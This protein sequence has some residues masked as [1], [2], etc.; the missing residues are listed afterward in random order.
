[1]FGVSGISTEKPA[2]MNLTV[3]ANQAKKEAADR[4]DIVKTMELL[5]NASG[6]SI[7]NDLNPLGAVHRAQAAANAPRAVDPA[8]GATG[9]APGGAPAPNPTVMAIL[10][11]DPVYAAFLAQNGML[12]GPAAPGALPGAI[13]EAV[14]GMAGE[15]YDVARDVQAAKEAA[16]IAAEVVGQSLG[17]AD[18]AAPQA[19][20]APALQHAAVMES[21]PA[22]APAGT[23]AQV[24]VM[25]I[26][27]MMRDPGESSPATVLHDVVESSTG[28]VLHSGLLLFETAAGLARCH[29]GFGDQG[30]MEEILLMDEAC[31]TE[32]KQLS[33]HRRR[34]ELEESADHRSRAQ[35]GVDEERMRTR[36]K[37]MR[38]R[39]RSLAFR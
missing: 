4:D 34:A 28:R 29:A 39:I 33:L 20:A 38:N 37:K 17:R 31:L 2:V 1:M 21:A 26:S 8:T 11:A 35:R 36:F 19:P 14:P 7:R 13:P 6:E 15:R 10:Q 22:P 27:I 30:V 32:I 25:G 23:Q 3:A 12:G 5:E 9:A 18:G 24:G 16:D